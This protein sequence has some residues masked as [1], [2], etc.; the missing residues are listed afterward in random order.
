MRQ[1]FPKPSP[2]R[3]I[4]ALG[5][6]D[7]GQ[8]TGRI[9]LGTR[10]AAAYADIWA[11]VDSALTTESEPDIAPR[12]EHFRNLVREAG[13]NPDEV[14]ITLFNISGVTDAMIDRYSTLDIDRF[15]FGPPMFDRHGATATLAHLDTLQKYIDNY[16]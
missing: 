13:R 10:H 1:T 2:C 11:P 4:V 5:E 16:C 15:V 14:K 3:C 12:I 6:R 9:G 8:D 7:P